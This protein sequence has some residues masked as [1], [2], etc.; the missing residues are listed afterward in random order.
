MNVLQIKTPEGVVFSQIIASP[1]IRFAAWF[2]DSMVIS[3]I[4]GVLNSI[5]MMT[6]LVSLDFAI[7]LNTVAYFV[8]SIGYGIACEWAWRGQTVGKKFFR[9]RVVDAEGL[10]LQVNQVVIRNL[11]RFVDALPFCY[12]VG[13]SVCWISRLNQRLG[14]IAANT[15]V[16]RH[17]KVQ[18]PD[19]DQLLPD[20]FNSLRSYPHLE[21]RLRQQINPAEAAIA[22]R[23]LLRRDDFAD[24][25]RIQLFATLADY[26]R[27]KVAFPPEATD[28]MSD[29]RYLRN[30]VDILYRARKSSNARA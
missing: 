16:I 17:P 3:G 26:F 12:L 22:L 13:G 29:E 24:D 7:A 23:A 2:V 21:G 18:Q 5:L 1:V 8:V 4:I 14:D 15:M 25:A 19:L 30:V 9:L 6:A 20:K 27:D 28:G 11:L 10:R